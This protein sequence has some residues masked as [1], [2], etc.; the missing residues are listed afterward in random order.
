MENKFDQLALW[1]LRLNGYLTVQ[2]FIL[3]PAIRGGQRAEVDILGVRFPYSKEVA[4]AEMKR[5]DN[6]VFQDGK[7]D[8]IIAEVKS[9]ECNL[10]GPWTKPNTEN[11]EYVIKWLG[12]I[13]EV[14]VPKLA[15]DLYTNKVYVGNKCV[16]R[17]VCFG[18]QRSEQ[19][20]P[21]VVQIE[22]NQ[23]IDFF[24]DRFKQFRRQKRDI[25]QWPQF[26]KELANMRKREKF[27]AWLRS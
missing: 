5:D 14:E 19:L 20:S 11:W 24:L 22:F 17:L 25:E 3:H 27:W 12:M 16:I 21:K 9:E 15:K 4:G 18:N 1:Y 26:I 2:H 6:L 10:N 23:V 7:I 8:F 13:P